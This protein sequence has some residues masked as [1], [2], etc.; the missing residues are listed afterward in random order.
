MDPLGSVGRGKDGGGPAER[1]LV[2][3]P[4]GEGSVETKWSE[5]VRQRYRR[6]LLSRLIVVRPA[7]GAENSLTLA[8]GFWGRSG[9]GGDS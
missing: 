4:S 8:V 6:S 7:F 3:L 2:V 1:A 9:Q 5:P